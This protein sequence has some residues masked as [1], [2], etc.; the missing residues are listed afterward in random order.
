MTF[1]LVLILTTFVAEVAHHV[2][3]AV[4]HDRNEARVAPRQCLQYLQSLPEVFILQ[5]LLEEVFSE[6]LVDLHLV[7]EPA[8][9]AS[10]ILEDLVG[11]LQLVVQ[12]FR[13]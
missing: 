8:L 3:G 2:Y 6:A 9:H 10:G 1:V 13:L 7:L 11:V 12:R 5:L 4:L